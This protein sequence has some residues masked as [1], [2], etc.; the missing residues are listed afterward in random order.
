MASSTQDKA[1]STTTSTCPS[2]ASTCTGNIITLTDNSVEHL[3]TEIH[4]TADALATS[5]YNYVNS[6]WSGQFLNLRNLHQRDLSH[7]STPDLKK[8]KEKRFESTITN[9]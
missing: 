9:S 1:S 3:I 2:T 6:F 5:A 8:K 4:D 7:Q